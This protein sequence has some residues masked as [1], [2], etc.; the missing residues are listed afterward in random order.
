MEIAL[1]LISLNIKQLFFPHYHP[2][3]HHQTSTTIVHVVYISHI[4]ACISSNRQIKQNK[5]WCLHCSSSSGDSSS[6]SSSCRHHHHLLIIIIIIIVIVRLVDWLMLY[7]MLVWHKF[8][9][10]VVAD[11]IFVFCFVF[12]ISLVVELL[13]NLFRL[14]S[15]S[16]HIDI[17]DS[18]IFFSIN[19]FD[20]F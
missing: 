9:G 3:N 6:S 11:N 10:Y 13:R 2:Q 16:S 19:S 14:R 12:S 18:R 20:D 15:S 7:V 8:F 5:N 1:S 4:H 17:F